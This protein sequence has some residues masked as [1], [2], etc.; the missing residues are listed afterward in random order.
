MSGQFTDVSQV[1]KFDLTQEEY[2]KRQGI[3]RLD[4]ITCRPPSGLRIRNLTDFTKIP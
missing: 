2:E 1:E 3:V 4:T